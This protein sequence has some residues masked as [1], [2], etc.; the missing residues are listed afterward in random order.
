[1]RL[2]F[3]TNNASRPARR[4]SRTT[5]VELGVDAEPDD[6]VTSAQAAARVLA[7]RLGAGAQ[8]VAARRR[9]A[10]GGARGARASSRWASRRTTPVAVVTGYGP[11]VL[12][13]DIMRAAVLDP[14]RA[15][16]GGQQH[17]PD[18]PDGLRRWRPGTAS[19]WGCCGTSPASSRWWP[20]SPQRPLLDETV[21][22][23]GGERPLMVGDRLD[24]DI[25]GAH[26]AG[27]DSPAGADRGDRAGRPGR[28]ARRSCVR[29]TSPPTWPACSRRTPV[30][31]SRRRPAA[32]GGWSAAVR[33]RAARGRR[34]RASGGLVAGR[35][36]GGLA[37]TSTTPASRRTPRASPRRSPIGR[38]DG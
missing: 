15:A 4:R 32:L 2:A 26:N 12:W 27:V 7:D 31:E 17:R 29:R 34:G 16:V 30:P 23:V 33:R 21:R 35:G 22:R 6:V 13:R 25:E 38:G 8:V 18:H 11:D 28:G 14:R 36:G 5:C 37:R 9:R 24:T 10:R 3:V 19:W 20:A 1:M